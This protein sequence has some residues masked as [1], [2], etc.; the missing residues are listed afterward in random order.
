TTL[1][2]ML[3]ST[4]VNDFNK[5][6]R[7]YQVRLQAES[8]F[9]QD[10]RVIGELEVRNAKN[11]MVPVASLAQVEPTRGPPLVSRYNLFPTASITGSSAPGYSSGQALK[12]MQEVAHDALPDSMGFE[13]TAVAYQE[14][15]VGGQALWVFAMAVL[16]VYLVLAAQYESWFLPLA[17][18]L[19]VPLGIL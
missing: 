7:T 3:G 16:L 17:V 13:W 1:Q 19:V 8:E 11:Q 6:G 12:T 4:Y 2:G 9:R 5:F 14:Q 10:P 15:S 18:I